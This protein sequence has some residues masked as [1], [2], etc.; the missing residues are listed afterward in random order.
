LTTW[1]E[2]PDPS[3]S[4]CHAWSAHP[5]FHL[6]NIAAGIEPI[7]PGCKEVEIRPHLGELRW[8]EASLPHP[9]GDIAVKFRRVGKTGLEASVSLPPGITGRIIWQE[10]E[11]A[12]SGE[13][14][15]KF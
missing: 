14:S 2:I 15:I 3:R 11:K 1:A 5:N 12:L 6:L 13:S 8:L 10:R 9:R 4:D 7:A